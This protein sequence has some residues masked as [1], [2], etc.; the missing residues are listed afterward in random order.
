MAGEAPINTFAENSGAYALARPRYPKELFE[1]VAAQAPARE[2][3]WDC[4][5]GNGQAA[6]GL[7]AHFQDV[8]ATDIAPGQVEHGVAHP[9]IRYSSGPAERSGF[10]PASFDAVAVAQA[11]HWFDLPHFWGEVRRVARPGGLFC[12]WGYAWFRYGTEVEAALVDPV[13][14]LV[15]P[16]WAANNRIL[17]NGYSDADIGFPFQRIAAPPFALALDTTAAGIAAYVRTWS[18]FKRAAAADAGVAAALED[19]LARG[20]H[21]LGSDRPVRA[22][23]PLALV[24]GRVR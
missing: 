13:K 19:A 8:E 22:E 12:A 3:V 6:I 4:A 17:W 5:T 14:A 7:A 18:A 20:L 11:L 24:A 10:A 15:E 16:Y 21:L 2:R 9:R 1:W 23:T